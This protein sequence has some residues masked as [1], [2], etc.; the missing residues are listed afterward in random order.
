MCPQLNKEEI[1]NLE[2]MQRE[3]LARI[4]DVPNSTPYMGILMETGIWTMEARLAYKKL[5]LYHNILHSDEERIIKKILQIQKEEERSG[6]WNDGVQKMVGYYGIEKDV[7]E[8]LKS[9]WKKEVKEKIRNKVAA[10]VKEKCHGMKKTRSIKNDEFV[11]KEYLEQTTLT[12]ATDI[13][14]TR[15]RA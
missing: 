13:I 15:L 9:E 8:V 10:E 4:L 7:N 14:R 3:I 5:M 12:E 1:K 11:M 2:S 6:T